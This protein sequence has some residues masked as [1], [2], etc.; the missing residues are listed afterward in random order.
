MR[1]LA[2]FF[3]IFCDSCCKKLDLE[4]EAIFWRKDTEYHSNGKTDSVWIVYMPQQL[5]CGID[6]FHSAWCTSHPSPSTSFLPFLSS[7]PPRSLRQYLDVTTSQ[8]DTHTHIWTKFM[9]RCTRTHMHTHRHITTHARTGSHSL[10]HTYTHAQTI[11][12]APTVPCGLWWN[13]HTAS[14]DQCEAI[15]WHL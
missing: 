10:T 8:T 7:S 2:T 14:F 12:L 1:F 4:L 13:W 3:H 6:T 11:S 9:C 15:V 5:F